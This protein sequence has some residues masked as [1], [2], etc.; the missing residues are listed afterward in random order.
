MFNLNILNLKYHENKFCLVIHSFP[1]KLSLVSRGLNLILDLVTLHEITLYL[2]QVILQD[3]KN[4]IV[5]VYK[6]T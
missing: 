3:V 5:L 1:Y 4:S 2:N 6:W